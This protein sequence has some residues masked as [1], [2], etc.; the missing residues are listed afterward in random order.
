MVEFSKA[1]T[2]SSINKSNFEIKKGNF[3]L[4]EDNIQSINL[5]DANGVATA[6]ASSKFVKVTLKDTDANSSNP[7][8]STDE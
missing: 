3:V 1:V 7:L 2:N 4:G 5:V 6:G 8:Y